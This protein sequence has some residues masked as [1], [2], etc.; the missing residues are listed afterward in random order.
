VADQETY[1]FDPDFESVITQLSMTDKKFWGRIGKQLD[2]DGL[3]TP[4]FKKSLDACRAIFSDGR[5]PT[6]VT[7][8]QRIKR[9]HEQGK[10]ALDDLEDIEEFLEVAKEDAGLYDAED[11]INELAPILRRRM[12]KLGLKTAIDTF[13]KRG[14]MDQAV[15]LFQRAKR[16]GA[17]GVSVGKRLNADII[18]DIRARASITRIPTGIQELDAEL[19]GGAKR[20]SFCVVSASTGVGKSMFL[21]HMAAQA[22][23]QGMS[24]AVAS[25]ELSEEDQHARIISNLVDIPTDD[26]L[27]YEKEAEEARSRLQDLEDLDM[28]GFCSVAYFEPRVTTIPDIISWVEA[29]QDLYS[30]QFDILVIDYIALCASTDKKLPGWQGLTKTCEEARHYGENNDMLVWSANQANA[31]GMNTK[32]TKRLDNHHAAES[33]GVPKTSD[34]HITANPTEEEMLMWYIAKNRHGPAGAEVGPLPVEFEKG[35]AAPIYRENWPY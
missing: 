11:I 21:G 18:T 30:V 15:D 28:L 3:R 10:I 1:G 7:V 32:K 34:L 27:I 4:A 6:L 16:I 13:S 2:P 8:R 35:R 22:V 23:S 31:D 29:E 33:K 17:S 24:V 20:G 5:S 26:I 25:L 14:D 12:E 19:K 9:W